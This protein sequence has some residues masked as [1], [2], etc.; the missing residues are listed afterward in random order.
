MIEDA[1]RELEMQWKTD[2]RWDGIERTTRQRMCRAC[3]A[4]SS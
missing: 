4:R 3:V 1:A 2:E